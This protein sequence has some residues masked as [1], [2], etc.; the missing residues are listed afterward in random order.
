MP[1]KK[2]D[3]GVI[4]LRQVDGQA[5]TS[6]KVLEV[7]DGHNL[8]VRAWFVPP[9]ASSATFVDL[10]IRGVETGGFAADQAAALPQVWQVTGNQTLSTT[11]GGRS[12]PL[13]EP[14]GVEPAAR[15]K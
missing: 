14:L 4:S 2:G 7:V 6:V 8:I 9:G 10:W 1:P 15:E 12:L 11:C 3:V 5:A 13:L